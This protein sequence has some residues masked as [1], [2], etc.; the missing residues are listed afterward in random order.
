MSRIIFTLTVH[1]CLHLR[2]FT[3]FS[4]G[5]V[6]FFKSGDNETKALCELQVSD[7]R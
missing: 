4:D 5:F 3:G 7:Q 6:S 1:T 2:M